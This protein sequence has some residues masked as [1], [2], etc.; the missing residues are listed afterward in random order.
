VFTG[1]SGRLGNQTDR[2]APV[3]AAILTDAGLE[4]SRLILEV[5]SRNTWENAIFS[6]PLANPQPGETWV[7]VTSAW[8]MP[9]A[10]GV[11]CAAGWPVVP[12]PVDQRSGTLGFRP[13]WDLWDH[14]DALY[15]GIREWV[16]LLAYG[17]SGRTAECEALPGQEGGER[18][19]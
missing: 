8:H 7:L 10:V 4:R 6:R 13:D 19:P 12:Y 5:R 9:R 17:L 1:G 3:A 11:F 16:G 18:R 15:L 2:A 14:G